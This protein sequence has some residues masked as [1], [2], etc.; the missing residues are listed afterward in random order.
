MQRRRQAIDPALVEPVGQIAGRQGEQE[1]GQELAQTHQPQRQRR[2]LH[3]VNLP[4][5]ATDW[6]WIA[7]VATKRELMK[8]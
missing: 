6:T 7:T 2:P 4:A 5:D 1:H 3:I 8:K